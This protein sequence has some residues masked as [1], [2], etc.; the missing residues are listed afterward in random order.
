L[1]G[2]L[3]VGLPVSFREFSAFL[4]IRFEKA[5]SAHLSSPMKE[6]QVKAF[7]K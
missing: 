6:M 4:F 7:E 3:T 5:L 1:K 2:N